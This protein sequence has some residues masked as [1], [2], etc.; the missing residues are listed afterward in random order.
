MARILLRERF[1]NLSEDPFVAALQ[2]EEPVA[3]AVVQGERDDLRRQP[4]HETEASPAD[5]NPLYALHLSDRESLGRSVCV[6][7][8]LDGAFLRG[9]PTFD[10]LTLQRHLRERDL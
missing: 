7:A 9:Q 2:Q 10:R 1:G 6:V 4:A 8:F 5:G 3:V